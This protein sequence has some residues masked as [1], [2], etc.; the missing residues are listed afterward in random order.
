MGKLKIL[1]VAALPVTIAV[2]V[3]GAQGA[4]AS[5]PA[6][7]NGPFVAYCGTQADFG[8]PVLVIDSRGGSAALNNPVIGWYD[9]TS[10]RA[11]DWFQLPYGGVPDAGYMFFFAPGGVLS[12]MCMSD[13]G[14]GHVVL[15][16]CNGSNWQRWIR[17]EVPGTGGHSWINRATHGILSAAPPGAQLV[18]VSPPSTPPTGPQLWHFS[19]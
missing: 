11:T 7:T 13:P 19:R 2:V 17:T 18:T 10:D 8:D 1:L 3:L 16:G 4:R 6:C 12:G 9:S 5:T 14:T 15:R